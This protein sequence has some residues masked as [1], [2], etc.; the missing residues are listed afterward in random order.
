MIPVISDGG[1]CMLANW[2]SLKHK[3]DVG[4]INKAMDF[5]KWLIKNVGVLGLPLPSYYGDERHKH[6]AEDFMRF[7]FHKVS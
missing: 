2:T 4:K 6:M 5:T 1:Y 3:I 7:C